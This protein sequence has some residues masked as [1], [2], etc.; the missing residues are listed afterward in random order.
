MDELL[1]IAFGLAFFAFVFFGKVTA[2]APYLILLIGKSSRMQTLW[3]AALTGALID[4]LS[5]STFF[6][7]HTLTYL[8]T[9][10]FIIP[11]RHFFFV[12]KLQ[13]MFSYVALFAIIETTLSYVGAGMPFPISGQALLTEWI[14]MPLFDGL[15]AIL[16]FSTPLLLYTHVK[17]L[18]M[19]F[20]YG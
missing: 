8:L 18:Y 10:L 5:P 12:D 14:M 6:G 11:F 2:F 19:R 13:G 1:K 4:A 7:L 20:K 16:W 17:R 9:I 3:A 15:Y